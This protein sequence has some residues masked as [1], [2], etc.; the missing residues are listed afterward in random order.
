MMHEKIVLHHLERK[1][2][3]MFG[4]SRPTRFYTIAK[5]VAFNTPCA[6]A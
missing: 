1:G 5:A 2:S 3:C 4:G 6:I